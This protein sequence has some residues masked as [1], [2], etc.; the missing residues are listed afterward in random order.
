MEIFHLP[1][2]IEWEEDRIEELAATKLTSQM[3]KDG[4]FFWMAATE[5]EFC[6]RIGNR[7]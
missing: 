5:F 6:S 4:I 7:K 3:K 2:R 1:S